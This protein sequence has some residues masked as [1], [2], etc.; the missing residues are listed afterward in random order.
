[1]TFEF[2]D[3]SVLTDFLVQYIFG[4]TVIL[5]VFVFLAF[6]MYMTFNGVPLPVALSIVLPLSV[7]LSAS[8]WFGQ[9]YL[10]ALIIIVIGL[11]LSNIMVRL[12]VR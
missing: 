9:S 6:L 3:F 4:N 2:S 7:A 5:G 11:V 12:Y 1:M 10:I 8:G